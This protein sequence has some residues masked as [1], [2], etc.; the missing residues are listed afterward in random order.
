VGSDFNASPLVVGE[1]KIDAA[2]MLG[3]T[4]VDRSSRS[5]K[6]SSG[7]Q[8]IDGRPDHV[9]ALAAQSMSTWVV[10]I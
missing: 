4:N 8:M 3:Y 10:L 2:S 5:V 9:G 1:I 7:F 6:L